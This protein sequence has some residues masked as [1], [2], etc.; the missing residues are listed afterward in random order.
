MENKFLIYLVIVLLFS[1]IG[2]FLR[3]HKFKQLKRE[4]V[5]KKI[6]SFSNLLFRRVSART[7]NHFTIGGKS[8]PVEVYFTR[9]QV[10][11]FPTRFSLFN[12]APLPLEI[13]K[14]LE[15]IVVNY[16]EDSIEVLYTQHK[17]DVV[18]KGK[19]K[20]IGTKMQYGEI[21]EFLNTWLND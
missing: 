12:S 19:F 8:I 3:L 2:Y 18:L 9:N 10:V 17:D 5:P 16:L 14:R 4:I 21:K 13:N 11:V 1:V 7:S 20:L 6:K 15:D